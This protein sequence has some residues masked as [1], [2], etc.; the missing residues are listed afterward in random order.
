MRRALQRPP[1]LWQEAALLV[2]G[3]GLYSMIQDDVPLQAHAAY[4]RGRTLLDLEQRWHIDLLHPLN[5]A[6]PKFEPLAVLANYYYVAMHFMVPICIL[7]WLI[8]RHVDRYRAERRAFVLMALIGLAVF[9]F[10]PTAPPRLIPGSGVL[11]TVSHFHTIGSYESGPTKVAADQFASMPSL[12]FA[13]ALW[14]AITMFRTA[15]HRGVRYGWL[16]YPV[17]T[18]L[19]V[20]A[21]GNHYVL[22]LPAGA[23]ALGLG[24]LISYAASRWARRLDS[25]P[26]SDPEPLSPSDQLSSPDQLSPSD[27]LGS[28][29]QLSSSG[30]PTDRVADSGESI[31]ESRVSQSG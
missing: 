11:D 6:L 25:V 29:G 26:L 1:R 20:L 3:F 2:L 10:A 4:D 17:L 22:D 30:G 15:K 24:Y 8:F 12:H 18:G 5:R 31:D 28:P 14:C 27:Q 9:W 7:L 13:F 21:T 16:V 23:A 19:D